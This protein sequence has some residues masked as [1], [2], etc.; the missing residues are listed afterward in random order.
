MVVLDASFLIDLERDHAGAVDRLREYRRTG[1]RLILPAMAASQ[2]IVGS[3]N[4]LVAWRRLHD[5]F[6]IMPMGRD[7]V[8]ET[9]RLG[10][11]AKERG[12]RPHWADLCIAASASLHGTYVVTANPT[13][14]TRVD[15]PVVD[16]RSDAGPGA[17]A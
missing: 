11:L 17:A 4:P 16:H 14:F 7:E 9:A 12:L 13:D 6:E 3:S 8:M 2:Y 5:A 1:E 15:V 10:R